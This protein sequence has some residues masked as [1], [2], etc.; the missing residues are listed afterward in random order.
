MREPKY[1]TEDIAFVC[2][3]ANR[4]LQRIQS[5][6]APSLPWDM[7]GAETRLSAIEGVQHAMA[8][9]SPEQLHETWCEFKTRNG[10]IY[11][12]EKDE[13]KKTH[14]CLVPYEDLPQAQRDKDVVFGAIVKA[15]T[16]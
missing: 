6:P 2:H 4:A 9:H 5:D 14:P 16:G 10:W 13:C 7:A 3:E 1:R 8:G 15:L 11:G 12:P